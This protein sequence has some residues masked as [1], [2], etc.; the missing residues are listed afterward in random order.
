[1]E[2]VKLGVQMELL[3]RGGAEGKRL[4]DALL[5]YLAKCGG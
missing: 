4:D 5:G 3:Q 1:L 2:S